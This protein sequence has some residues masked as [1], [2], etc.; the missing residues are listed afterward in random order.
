MSGLH[1]PDV[2]HVFVVRLSSESTGLVQL[3][4]E[5]DAA[6]RRAGLSV[7]TYRSKSARLR[8]ESPERKIDLLNNSD[9]RGLYRALHRENVLVLSLKDIYVRRD[10]SCDPH[11]RAQAIKLSVF[12][13]HK[14]L[15]GLVHSG[16]DIDRHLTTFAESRLEPAGCSG[17][18]DP[19]AL[20]LHVFEARGDWIDL[21][22][23]GAD[24]DFR[25]RFGPASRRR[26]DG[27]KTWDRTRAL[28]G[29]EQLRVSRCALLAGSHWDVVSRGGTVM[30]YTSDEIWRLQARRNDYL[31]VYPDAYVRKTPRSVSRRVWPRTR[32]ARSE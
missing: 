25:D 26:D 9:A 23:R 7:T 6:A 21:G 16:A 8:A 31:N 17:I 32:P 20:P 14:A 18:D 19:R 27:G 30:L 24:T 13:R 28:H 10:P 4:E 2:G 22:T 15:F 29:R 1:E 12:V 11:D 5:C 3:A